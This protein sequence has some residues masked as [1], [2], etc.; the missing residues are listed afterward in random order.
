MVIKVR[1]NSGDI[2]EL[3]HKD[4]EQKVQKKFTAGQAKVLILSTEA[5]LDSDL[6]DLILLGKG[7]DYLCIDIENIP[8]DIQISF[9]EQDL[10]IILKNQL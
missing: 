1:S 6:I 9:Q 8:N 10:K 2:R 4:L 3:Y 5:D 7:V